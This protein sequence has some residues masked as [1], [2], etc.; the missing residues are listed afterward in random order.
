VF[1][2]QAA[3]SFAGEAVGVVITRFIAYLLAFWTVG[4]HNESKRAGAGLAIGA[5]SLAVAAAGDSR[6]DA[7]NGANA[8]LVAAAVWLAAVVLGRRARRA[9]EL[10]ARA[11][12]LEREREERARAAAVAERARI[13]RE[14]HDVI[15]HSVSVMTVQAGAA[16]VLLDEA[17]GR[18]RESLRAVE[19]T[20][21]QA[22]AE[23]RRLLGI[24][25]HEGGPSLAPQ[26]GLADLEALVEQ[27]RAGGLPVELAVEGAREPLPPG[28]DLAAYRIVQEALTNA[29]RH[30]GPAR[31]RV[32]VRY[33]G[34][35]LGL[36]VADDGSRASGG[37]G[38]GHGLV[39]MRERVALYG[40]ELQAGPRPGGGFAVRA[41]LP[42][43]RR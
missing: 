4:A 14:L 19:E 8:I 6:V 7:F 35:A 38:D 31:A 5:A 28:V 43:E 23:M 30:A 12:G 9:G 17:P 3:T 42:T 21:R 29:R 41:R 10:E 36:E 18:A 39:G 11:A 15:A 20:G 34:G 22:L 13:A 32:T 26:P 25:R 37:A 33:G 2:V 40:G 24:L 1:V 16:R 27:A